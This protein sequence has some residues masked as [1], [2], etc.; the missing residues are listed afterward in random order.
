LRRIPSP[1]EV[2]VSGEYRLGDNRH[3]VSDVDKLKKL[4]WRPRL[5]LQAILDDFLEWVNS[6]GGIP[7]RI[8]DADAD[9]RRAGVVLTAQAD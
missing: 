2:R 5:G 4:G 6:I 9:M 7:E 1:A 8:R 3:S